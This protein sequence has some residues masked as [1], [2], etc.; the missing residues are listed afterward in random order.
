ME[1]N[2]KMQIKSIKKIYKEADIKYD[3]NEIKI[4]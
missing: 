2:G 1:L 3:Y 4:S